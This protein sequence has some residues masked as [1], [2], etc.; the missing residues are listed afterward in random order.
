MQV[1]ELPNSRV[2]LFARYEILKT[3]VGYS[4]CSIFS[5]DDVERQ[6]RS[7]LGHLSLSH[8][9]LRMRRKTRVVYLQHSWMCAQEHGE[10][11]R[12]VALAFYSHLECFQTAQQ[13]RRIVWRLKSASHIRHGKDTMSYACLL[14][15]TVK[16]K[17]VS[18]VCIYQKGT[19]VTG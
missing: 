10:V 8:V 9:M 18:Q 14:L 17:N 5:A 4:D 16:K 1:T 15:I 19:W 7:K 11:M 3:D 2:K 13:Q 12:S 6:H